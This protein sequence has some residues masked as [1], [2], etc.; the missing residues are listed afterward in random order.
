VILLIG[1]HDHHYFP[2]MKGQTAGFQEKMAVFIQQVLLENKEHLQMAFS[3]NQFL[4]SHAGITKNFLIEAFSETMWDINSLAD[5]V[6]DLWRW[7]PQCF[8]FNTMCSDLYGN[9]VEQSPIWI[10]PRALM[11][12]AQ[13]FK[14]RWIQVVGHTA[15]KKVDIKG[16]AT[17]GRY[18]FIDALGTSKEYLVI[19]DDGNVTTKVAIDQQ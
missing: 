12:G 9:S 7:T 17:G 18:Y 8:M 13:D 2:G 1:N 5:D 16:K 6:N 15:V 4:F 19:D 11:K 14:K 3:F 10:R